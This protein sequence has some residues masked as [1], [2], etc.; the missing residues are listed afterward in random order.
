MSFLHDD[1]IGGLNTFLEK[2]KGLPGKVTV[3]AYQFD[4]VYEPVVEY[5]LLDTVKPFTKE[6]FVPRGGTALLDAIGRTVNAKGQKFAAM[7]EK[8]RPE[9]VILIIFTDGLENSS[10]EF[11]RSQV[12]SMLKHQQELY[13]W[14]VIYLGA[15]QDAIKEGSNLGL[16][17]GKSMNW[18]KTSGGIRGAC[19]YASTYTAN[20]RSG[21]AGW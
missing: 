9:K 12:Q 11:T 18:E 14:E 2:Q 6:H 4:E 21:K 20:Y 15:D 13:S 3:S 7:D 10:K 8:D 1:V 17:A 16:V 5:A 19:L